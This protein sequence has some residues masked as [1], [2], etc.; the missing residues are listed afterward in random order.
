MPGTVNLNI[1]SSIFDRERELIISPDFI[2]YD[3]EGMITDQP[4]LIHKNE[5]KAFRYGVKWI[6]GYSFVI[7]RTYCLDI[8]TTGNKVLKI[9]LKSMYGIRRNQLHNKFE[10]IL[11]SLYENHFNEIINNSLSELA[12]GKNIEIAGV[13]FVQEGVFTHPKASMIP[14]ENVGTKAYT[15]YYTIFSKSNPNDYKA[16]DYIS[17]WNAAVLYSVLETILKQMNR[18]ATRM[19]KPD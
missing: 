4:S 3:I 11:D 13:N 19:N 1:K 12:N 18:E 8:L 10:R 9:R 5:I 16:F 7:G 17:H 6:N 15:S 14:W 2:S